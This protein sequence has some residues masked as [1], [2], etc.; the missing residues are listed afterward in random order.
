MFLAPILVSNQLILNW[1]G[2]GQLQ[3]APAVTGV[4]T[5]ITPAPNPPYTN[6][7]SCRSKTGSSASSHPVR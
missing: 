2:P 5:N 3:S 6:V 7:I 1:T 4:Y